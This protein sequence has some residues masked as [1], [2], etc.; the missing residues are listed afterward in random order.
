MK[1]KLV[2]IF[3]L[4][5]G[6]LCGCSVND[7]E[8]PKASHSVDLTEVTA[9]PDSSSGL[10]AS[11][12]PSSAY[13]SSSPTPKPA[14]KASLGF[15]GD[16]MIMQS[17]VNTAK[18]P[19]GTYDFTDSFLPMQKLFEDVDLM[20]G[21]LETPLAGKS[22]GGYSGPATK[23]FQ[24]FNAP[25]EL[26]YNLKALGVDVLTTA[27][28]HCLDRGIE[29]LVRTIDVLRNAKLY[30]TGTY[31]NSDDREKLLIVD[32]NGIKVGI[33]AFSAGFNTYD[34]Q[35]SS[36]DLNCISKFYD[37]DFVKSQIERMRAAGADYI[38]VEPHCGTEL[39]LKPEERHKQMFADF[40][41][42]GADAVIASH[43][44][45]VQPIEF[46][47]VTRTDGTQ[48]TVPI[49]YSL[50]NF[51]SNMLPEPKNY[52]L[53]VRLDIE[54]TESGA[55]TTEL[56][57]M[58]VYCII[59]ETSKGRLHQTLPCPGDISTIKAYEP[60]S[61][62]EYESCSKCRNFVIDICG[63]EYVSNK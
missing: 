26:A 51:I 36:S 48:A 1:L 7:S 39:S 3:M 50:G 61:P 24:T 57:Y 28:N 63:A 8:E 49:V 41:R 12:T 42:W 40:A 27:N 52:G 16:I 13:V 60:L 5:L 21:N 10:D 44:H 22:N 38:V 37:T 11:T 9:A 59:Q 31:K 4:M 6:L 55:I 53:Y 17:Q 33:L 62:T 45:V 2:C 19:N 47:D 54:K 35:L 25:D 18:L 29:G 34:R 14:V 23:P 32:I 20:C 56:S 15:V 46:I 43:P 30:S 58:P